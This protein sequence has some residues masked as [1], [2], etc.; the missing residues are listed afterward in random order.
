MKVTTETIATREVELTIEPDAQAVQKAMRRAAQLIS[1]FRPVPGYRP[2]KAPFS[3]VERIFGRD[4]ILNEAIYQMGPDLYREAV[5]EAGI[6]PYEQG[7][8]DVE[9]EDPL[10]LKANVSLVP[11]V[12]LGDYSTLHVD[13]EPDVSITEEQIDEQV[14]Q[15]RKRFAEHD[16]VDRPVQPG[17]QI[18]AT[19]EGAAGDDKVIDRK[20]AT[21]IVEDNMQPPGFAE[22]VTGMSAGEAREF[23]L[24]YPEDYENDDLAGK[25]V[26]FT[27]SVTTVRDTTLPE[28]DDDLAKMA[29]DFDTLQELRDDLANR[30][31][32][33]LEWELRERE[34]VA[35]V[36]ALVANSKVEYPAAALDHEVAHLIESQKQRVQQIGFTWERYLQLMG[37]SEAQ[38]NENSR[39]EAEQRLVRRLVLTEFA[40]AEEITVDNE[41]LAAGMASLA[42]T[43]G[44]QSEE[45]QA[46]LQD[47]RVLM[48]V[49]SDLMTRKAMNRLRAMLTGRQEESILPAETEGVATESSPEL[50]GP[51]GLEQPAAEET[52][53]PGGEASE[54]GEQE[55]AG[56]E[57]G[58]A[59]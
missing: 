33:R 40:R 44:E 29:G 52:L 21:L 58:E 55:M 16:P 18:I 23:T 5:K 10:V 37:T 56:A 11:V 32:Q 53:V 27:V 35:V 57:E 20:D 19:I 46:Q 43:W 47:Q 22:A 39:P 4:T 41:E 26:Q 42:A 51:S 36:E 50:E 59:E 54:A 6:E 24:S 9:S 15:T 45:A 25:D 13:P 14:E 2:G 8:L 17:D 3:L 12:N 34:T 38:V 1:R 48:S 7:E 31:K 30:L 49:Y 28:V